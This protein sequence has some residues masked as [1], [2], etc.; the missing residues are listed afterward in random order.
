MKCI[1]SLAAVSSR[2]VASK[3][4]LLG[5]ALTSVLSGSVILG[6]SSTASAATSGTATAQA[7]QDFLDQPVQNRRVPNRRS[8]D[9]IIQLV[10]QAASQRSGI[11]VNQLS[12]SRL[13]ATTFDNSCSFNF[14]EICND[15]YQPISGWKAIVNVKGQSWLYHVNRSGSRIVLDPKVLKEKPVSTMPGAYI[16][17]VTTDAA[18]RANISPADVRILQS[19]QKTFGNPCEFNFGEICTKE[20]NP[21]DGYEVW[22]QVKGQTWKYHVDRAGR[23]VVLDPKVAASTAYIMP[24]ALQTRILS[25]AAARSGLPASSLQISQA[26]PRTFSNACVFG[27]GEMCPMI[28]QPIEGWETIVQVRDQTWAYHIDRTGAQLAVDPR[29]TSVG[30]L[31]VSVENAVRQNAKTWTNLPTLKIVSARSQT[32]GNDCAF[33][34]GK[35]CPA[36]YQP[37]DGWEVKVNSGALEWTYHTNRDGSLVVMDRRGIL[38]SKVADAIARDIVKR[39]GPLVTPNSLR[40]LEV[41]EQSKRVCFLFSGCRNELAYLAIVSN[42]R[43]QWGYQSDDQGRQ[44]LPVAITQVRQ[45]SDNSVSQR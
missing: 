32:W 10:L 17:A 30:R 43:Q 5:L 11:P 7:V 38:P 19:R 21:I 35:L 44:V 4:V 42:G 12:L 29:V 33:N 26:T 2:T 40:F 24:V 28:Y 25:D 23:R 1:H 22:A 37:V 15:I 3:H 45:A 34:F 27:F 18:R 31:P 39:S 16:D 14:G 8:R 41:K 13:T 36:N 6:I 9:A 20:Y